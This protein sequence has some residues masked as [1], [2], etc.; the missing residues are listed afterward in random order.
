MYVFLTFVSATT[1]YVFAVS[2]NVPAK[3]KLIIARVGAT[4]AV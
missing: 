3:L 4:A 2:G 1:L